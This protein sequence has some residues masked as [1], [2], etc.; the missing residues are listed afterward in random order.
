MGIADSCL[1]RSDSYV[2]MKK[3]VGR[4]NGVPFRW[5]LGAVCREF[6]QRLFVVLYSSSGSYLRDAFHEGSVDAV[7]C[8]CVPGVE[9]GGGIHYH[10][11]GDFHYFVLFVSPGHKNFHTYRML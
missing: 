4:S 5:F 2:R 11:L 9:L 6:M 7:A 3:F 1:L 10:S 8:L